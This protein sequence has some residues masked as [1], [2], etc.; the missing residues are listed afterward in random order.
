MIRTHDAVVVGGGPAGSITAG[1]L[2]EDHDIVVIEEHL[3][4]GKPMQCAGLVTQSVL[5]M[6]KVT[7][8]I[9]NK[10]RGAD[11]VFPKG[12]RIEVRSENTKALLID[13]S[14]LDAKLASRAADKGAVF[15]YGTKYIRHT[16]NENGVSVT[17][18]KEEFS[19]KLIIGADGQGSGVAMSLGKNL[20]K[21]YVYGME[22][23]V[24]HKAEYD[25]IMI[26]RIGSEF[27]PGFF[28]WEIPFGDTVR[29]GMCVNPGT[30]SPNT[31][32]KKLL[33][34]L[35]IDSGNITAKYAG[36]I[37]LGGRPR[38]YGD[39]TLLIGDAAGQVKPVSGGGLYPLCKAAP[40]L[41]KTAKESLKT[42]NTSSKFLSQY[43]KNWKKE[44][45]KELSRGY[46][47]RRTY[48]SLSDEEF[49]KVYRTIDRDDIRA[50]LN[51]IDIDDP[52]GVALPM[53]KK[54]GV[55]IRLL[56]FILRAIV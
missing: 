10:I 44:M 5:D 53:M 49:E 54:P 45:G 19:S 41:C 29:V 32:L 16:I 20:P 24:K 21:E 30:G 37:P 9:L 39:R 14:D 40:I 26:L 25:D 47:I 50:I 2:A 13:R 42:G 56:P 34:S 4:S 17:S 15:R 1:L 8:E 35:N 23:D 38:S 48:T 27:A 31:Y 46:R 33:S 7:P 43:E 51:N 36:K 28:S 18:D 11:V 12:G 22:A 52:S 6:C 3:S 55:G